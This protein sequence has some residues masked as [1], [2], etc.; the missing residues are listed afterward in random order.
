MSLVQIVRTV[1][2]ALIAGGIALGLIPQ[3]RCG[4]G[5]GGPFHAEGGSFGWF[6]YEGTPGT[7]IAACETVMAP[8]RSWAIALIVVGATLLLGAWFHT[9]NRPKQ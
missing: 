3:G 4:S 5:W 2:I 1:G 8:V 6:A 7:M 9:A